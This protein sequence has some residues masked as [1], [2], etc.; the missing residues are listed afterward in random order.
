MSA[1]VAGNAQ[2]A[3]SVA[4][5][6]DGSPVGVDAVAEPLAMIGIADGKTRSG[7]LL[8]WRGGNR[9]TMNSQSREEKFAHVVTPQ[10]FRESRS[11]EWKLR[12]RENDTQATSGVKRV[13][14]QDVVSK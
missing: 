9:E 13:L 7:E 10:R 4:G 8:R 3:V 1:E 5:E 11:G 14:T 2:P 6:S 12:G